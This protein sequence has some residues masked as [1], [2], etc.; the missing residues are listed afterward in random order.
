MTGHHFQGQKVNWHGRAYRGGRPRT[1]CYAPASN[2]WGIKRCFYIFNFIRTQY[3]AQNIMKEDKPYL[4]KH[5]S[6]HK[7]MFTANHNLMFGRKISS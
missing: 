1:A 3:A 2:T 5:N 4:V 6:T 7:A